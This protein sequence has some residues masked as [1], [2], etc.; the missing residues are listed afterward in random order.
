MGTKHV[1]QVLLLGSIV[2]ALPG[3]LHSQYV[4]I[5]LDAGVG[6]PHDDCR[7]VNTEK[8]LIRGAV[9]LVQTLVWREVQHLNRMPI[10]VLEVERR[11]ARRVLIP[12][13]KPLW[14]R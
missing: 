2:F 13:R 8:Q 9:P 5:E 10:W 1:V 12:V 6:V 7:M 4:A 14:S 11:D 3:D